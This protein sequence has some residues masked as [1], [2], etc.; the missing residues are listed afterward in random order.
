[1][2]P[3]RQLIVHDPDAGAIGDCH[4]TCIASILDL[5][6][7]DVP[8]FTEGL[9]GEPHALVVAETRAWLA[10]RGL[11]YAMFYY[12]DASLEQILETTGALSPG[13]PMILS[14]RSSL[15]SNHAVVILDGRIASDPSGNGIVGPCDD[16]RWWVELLTVG[17]APALMVA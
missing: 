13:V 3:H 7:S 6:P 1:M 2:T 8:H 10:G 5:H 16:G 4:R 14:G 11:G 12:P 15:G 17:L 9:W